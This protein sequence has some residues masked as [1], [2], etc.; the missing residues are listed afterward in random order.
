MFLA[1]V[2]PSLQ[3][4]YTPQLNE[5]HSDWQWVPWSQV[6]EGSLELHPVVKRLADKHDSEV[7]N[8]LSSCT[9]RSG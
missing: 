1:E 2:H 3:Q 4:Q 5:E 9:Q 6:V 7:A 8:V